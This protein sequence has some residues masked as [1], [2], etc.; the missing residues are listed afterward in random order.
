MG[1]SCYLLLMDSSCLLVDSTII[2]L[3]S[4]FQGSLALER[5]LAS[6]VRFL[7]C[8]NWYQS[9]DCFLAMVGDD[10]GLQGLS[11]R[12]NT[13]E[14]RVDAVK[15]TLDGVVQEPKRLSLKIDDRNLADSTYRSGRDRSSINLPPPPLS[16]D[17]PQQLP[18][19]TNQLIFLHHLH[20]RIDHNNYHHITHQLIFLH[21]LHSRIHHNNHHHIV[22]QLIFLNHHYYNLCCSEIAVQPK[23]PQYY[24]AISNLLFNVFSQDQG[25]Q[26]HH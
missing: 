23:D 12:M 22:H 18:H 15:L 10:N 11:I 21:P 25:M 5:N 19:I 24:A 16:L 14:K 8:V 13:A 3:E 4:I 17:P 7:A 26:P 1:S 20:Y 9:F 6:I 2:L